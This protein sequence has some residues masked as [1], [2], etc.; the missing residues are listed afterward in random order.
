MSDEQRLKYFE[1]IYSRSIRWIIHV[2]CMGE[3]GRGNNN[4]KDVLTGLAQ[5]K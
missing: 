1:K 3:G 5:R 4:A 2:A